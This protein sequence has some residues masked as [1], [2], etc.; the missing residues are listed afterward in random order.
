MHKI[1]EG[2]LIEEIHPSH[3]ATLSRN[4]IVAQNPINPSGETENGVS[5]ASVDL[6]APFSTFN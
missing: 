5:N 3:F 6:K 4:K 1:S 2:A